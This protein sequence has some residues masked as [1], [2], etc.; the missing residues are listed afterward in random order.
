M[1][2]VSPTRAARSADAQ[3]AAL[4][5]LR[6]TRTALDRLRARERELTKDRDAAI[7]TLVQHGRSYDA[8]ARESGVTRGRVGQIV[9]RQARSNGQPR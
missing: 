5:C 8:V 7:V 9:Q 6:R 3:A 4:A 1:S 2:G